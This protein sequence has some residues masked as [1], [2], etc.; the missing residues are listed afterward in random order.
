MSWNVVWENIPRSGKYPMDEWIFDDSKMDEALERF[1]SEVTTALRSTAM[2]DGEP[3]SVGMQILANE[4]ITN[5]E[6]SL[7]S[8]RKFLLGDPDKGIAPAKVLKAMV[9][10]ECGQSLH[11][12]YKYEEP[13]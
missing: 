8:Y 11:S 12:I 4:F 2:V 3:T 1:M 5:K 10:G 9:V 6:E 7:E 13:W